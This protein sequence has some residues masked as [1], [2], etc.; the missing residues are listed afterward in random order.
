MITDDVPLAE[1]ARA[2][3]EIREEYCFARNDAHDRTVLDCAARLAAEPGGEWAYVWTIGLLMTAPYVAWAPGDGVVPQVRAALEAVDAALRDGP[4]EHGTHPWAEHEEEFDE[5]LVRQV[6]ALPRPDAPWEENH[7]R[8]EWLCPRN[9]AG[10][11]RIALDIIEPGSTTDVPPRLP[12]G[13]QDTIESLS[14]LLHGYP[15]PGADVAE[16]ISGQAEELRSADPA[17][18]P[19]H[20]LVAMAL[21][22]YATS[23]LVRETAVLDG[24]IGALEVTLPR[25]ADATCAHDRHPAPPRGGPDAASLGVRLSTSGGR[26]RY[27]ERHG[28]Q[29][30]EE[31][32]CPV[33]LAEISGKSL[34]ALRARREELRGE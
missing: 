22:W 4:C 13:T 9:V 21:T 15:E 2:W 7:S 26:A 19:G 20:V 24:L 33:A 32:L 34:S 5:D 11:A 18:R 6:C 31:L 1:L 3:D 12:V 25:Y 14:A 16:E 28:G 23:D 17:D 27:I 30:L 29:A 8:D 10:L